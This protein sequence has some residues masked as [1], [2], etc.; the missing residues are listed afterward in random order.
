MHQYIEISKE[1]K[2]ELKIIVDIK[3]PCLI[4]KNYETIKSNLNK[5]ENSV[6]IFLSLSLKSFN[7]WFSNIKDEN[8]LTIYPLAVPEKK[9]FLIK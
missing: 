6:D 5:V 9:L 7:S 1:I 8:K 3:T 4:D 2:K